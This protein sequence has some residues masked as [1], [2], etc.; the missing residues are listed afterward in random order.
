MIGVMVILGLIAL[1][2][3]SCGL[4]PYSCEVRMTETLAEP[5]LG[6]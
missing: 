5:L 3:Q 2:M 4:L 6:T 1:G